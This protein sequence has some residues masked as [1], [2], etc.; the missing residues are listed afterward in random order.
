[1][2]QEQIQKRL[3]ELQSQAKQQ[4]AVLL[5]ISGAIQDCHFWLAEMSKAE[6][7]KIEENV[8]TEDC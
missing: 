8:K 3:D 4:E 1:M 2:T 6:N 7:V 5:Q